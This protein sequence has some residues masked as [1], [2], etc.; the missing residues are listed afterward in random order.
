[1][2]AVINADDVV[3]TLGAKLKVVDIT[4]ELV[5][6]LEWEP[7]PLHICSTG[8]LDQL[9]H[10]MNEWTT[11]ITTETL[12]PIWRQGAVV[13]RADY[14]PSDSLFESGSPRL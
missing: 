9:T 5:D 6:M 10:E 14:Q 1:M 12:D 11:Y 8:D 4:T 2:T 7:G 3:K 13:Y